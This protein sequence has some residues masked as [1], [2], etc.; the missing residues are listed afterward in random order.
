MHEGYSAPFI[1]TFTS[2]LG[3]NYF[4]YIYD[5]GMPE[6]IIL[7]ADELMSGAID[8]LLRNNYFDISQCISLQK[9]AILKCFLIKGVFTVN[10]PLY[11]CGHPQ[12]SFKY[13]ISI[14]IDFLWLYK[15]LTN[16]LLLEDINYSSTDNSNGG[17]NEAMVIHSITLKSRAY[18]VIK[19]SS[20]HTKQWIGFEL[21]SINIDTNTIVVFELTSFDNKIIFFAS[22]KF[23]FRYTGPGK[24]A[25]CHLFLLQAWHTKFYYTQSHIL[26]LLLY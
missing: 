23:F 3:D 26:I 5:N 16:K 10:D 18:T 25:S 7:F 9:E 2:N 4:S 17:K 15:S 21:K 14:L 22:K 8:N 19:H 11:Y 13:G 6:Y 12:V 24:R 20:P 1:K